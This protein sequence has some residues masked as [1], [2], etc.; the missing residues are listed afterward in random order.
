MISDYQW[1]EREGCRYAEVPKEQMDELMER[2]ENED[3]EAIADTDYYCGGKPA[4]IVFLLDASASIW[5]PDFKKQTKFVEDV[6]SMFQI[7][8][9]MTQVGVLTYSHD[10]NLEFP[11]NRHKTK[12]G[13]VRAI[14]RI[15]H[16]P[17]FATNTALGIKYMRNNM[18]TK[19]QG[20]RENVVRVAIVMTDGKS[21]NILLTLWQASRARRSAHINIFSIGIGDGIHK[22]ELQGIAGNRHH[23]FTV[24]NYAALGSIRE[25]LAI[26]TCRATDPPTRSTRRATVPVTTTWTTTTPPP[27]T[28]PTTTTS[29]TMRATTSTTARPTTTIT[30]TT[31]TERPTSTTTPTTRM[32][33]RV[34]K[35]CSG[36]VLDVVIAADASD[37]IFEEEFYSQMDF[38]KRLI[39]MLDISN[40]TTRVGFLT[41]GKR[42]KTGFDLTEFNDADKIIN[43]IAGAK[44]LKGRGGVD[45]AIKYMRTRGFRRSL[46]RRKV[47]SPHIGLIVSGTKNKN[48]EQIE[49]EAK[50]AAKAGI[51]LFGVGV[52]PQVSSV[53]LENI[54]ASQKP[55]NRYFLANSYNNIDNILH[56]LAIQICEAEPNLVPVS[57]AGCGSRQPADVLFAH[58]SS[59][60]GAAKTRLT[61]NFIKS[62]VGEFDV[63]PNHIQVG[64]LSNNCPRSTGFSFGAHK[65]KFDVLNS[66]NALESSSMAQLIHKLRRHGFQSSNGKRTMAKKIGII[67]VDSSSEKP[68]TALEE[69]EIARS[70]GIEI[71]II[72]IGESFS[73]KEIKLLCSSPATEHLFTVR[74][75]EELE[76]IRAKVLEKICDEL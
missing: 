35:I 44:Q 51:A 67:I 13:L 71:F 10:V 73:K 19:K 12:Q 4:D 70:Q 8:P 1:C 47:S 3:L 2:C 72:A 5:G 14:Q 46:L 53:Q 62:I 32:V 33:D 31:T 38:L 48:L 36:K 52:S 34:L 7:S 29:T 68:L 65:N 30:T 41:F 27:S 24:D 26:E 63:D 64:L 20:A 66:L 57:D 11:L 17:G 39:R 9:D 21:S 75:Y 54:V 74:N 50:F 25:I 43:K 69:A 6:V 40:A 18:F 37:R 56:E 60:A 49:K 61:F 55:G 76:S 15:P 16:R 59:K 22:R 45:D 58:D 42:L 23:A 28:H